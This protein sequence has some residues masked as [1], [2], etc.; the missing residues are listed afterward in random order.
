M[1]NG[2]VKLTCELAM[3]LMEFA[4]DKRLMVEFAMDQ[5]QPFGQAAQPALNV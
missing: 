2:E 4:V 3:L 5:C 1:R